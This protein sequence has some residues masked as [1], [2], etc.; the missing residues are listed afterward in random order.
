MG[1]DRGPQREVALDDGQRD[2][3]IRVGGVDGQRHDL[4]EAA[5]RHLG[6]L[7]LAEQLRDL[8][9]RRHHPRAE[10]RGRDQHAGGDVARDHRAARRRR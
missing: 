2:A 6:V 9:H 3:V 5:H 1:E 4:V 7:E 8:G 10:D